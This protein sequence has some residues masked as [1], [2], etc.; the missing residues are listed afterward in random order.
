MRVIQSPDPRL[1]LSTSGAMS[2]T[3]LRLRSTLLSVRSAA[4]GLTSDTRFEPR[5][6]AVR[7]VAASRPERFV[8]A[9]L[10]ACR[11]VS[12]PMDRVVTGPST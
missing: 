7:P 4:R 3:R 2:E 5:K 8:T 1:R 9:A 10:N 12:L 11:R 6:S